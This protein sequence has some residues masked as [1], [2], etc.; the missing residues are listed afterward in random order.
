MKRT[1]FF[2]FF[3]SLLLALP[4]LSPVWSATNTKDF[5]PKPSPPRLVNDLA[6]IMTPAQQD[7]LERQLV[8]F[9]RSTSTQ[10]TI[11][12]V[13]SLGDYE[14][15][16]YA[17]Q[18]GNYWGVGRKEKNNGVIIL[19]SSED[20][21]INISPGQGL[22][23]V[24][25]DAMCGRIIRNEMAPDFRSSNYYGGLDKAAKAVIAAT[26]GEYT[27]EAP[28][29]AGQEGGWGVPLLIFAVIIIVI[30][31]AAIRGGGGKGGGRGNYMSRRG[32]DFLTGAILGSIFN[33][34]GGSG[35][36][37]WGG[38]GSNGGGGFGGFGG[39]SFGGGGAS[40]SW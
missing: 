40:G 15:A 29:D 3:L 1:A 2:S 9:D 24:L 33:S 35:G 11:V 39:G 25:T 26:K 6:G 21:K 32:S 17:T 18:L 19:V 27:A 12:T 16:D 28:P 31:I 10:I 38:G 37:G 30:V 20:R 8:E 13:K 23:G 7:E 22:E 34:G 36:S 14:P 5:P 4:G